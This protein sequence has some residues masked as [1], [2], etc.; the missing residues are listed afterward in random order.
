M[1][2]AG[3]LLARLFIWLRYLVALA[4]IAGAIAATLELP[5]V[6]TTGG[7]FNSLLPR[8]STALAAAKLSAG[9]F[10]LPVLGT[11]TM[12]VVRN[13]HGL[14]PSRQAQLLELAAQLSLHRLPDYRQIA[15][16]V[17]LVNTFGSRPLMRERGTTALL[18]LFFARGVGASRA[19]ALARR[20]IARRIGHR[21][22]EF[23]GLTGEL[24]AEAAQGS[25]LSS[26]LGLVE[27][28]T[29]LI[30]ALVIA[31]HF[32]APGAALLDVVTIALAFQLSEKV[33]GVLSRSAHLAFPS[34]L[35][36][37]AVVLVFGIVTDY[38]IFY[39][40]RFRGLLARGLTRREASETVL[41]DVGPIVLTAGITVAAGTIALEAATLG[42]LRSFGPGLAVAV[43]VAML[44][45][46]CF[47]PAVLGII[48]RAAFWPTLIKPAR[49]GGRLW[50][51]RP[52]GEHT[53]P[54]L[55]AMPEPRGAGRLS[56]LAERR[57]LTVRIAARHPLL[58][59]VLVAALIAA[60]ASGLR[61]TAVGNGL[62]TDLPAHS[63]VRRSFAQ[64]QR[65]FA[66]GVMAPAVVVITGADVGYRR[67]ALAHLQ[68]ELAH[69][70]GVAAVI[71][72]AQQPLDRRLGIVLAQSGTAARYILFLR[73]DPFGP[74]AIAAVARL[75]AQLP[76]LLGR[77]GLRIAH[78]AVTGDTAISADIV[79]GTI[80]SLARMVPATLVAIFIV[81][82]IF[83]R[84]LLAPAYLVITSLLAVA[85][86]LGLA[87]YVLQQLLGYGQLAFYVPFV[88]AVLMIS[89]GSDYN[90]FMVGQ[91]WHEARRRSLREAIEV[92]GSRAA[93][94]ITTAGFVLAA[95]F[96]LLALVPL[97]SFREIAFAMGAGL[98]IDALIV[99]ALLVP[100][101]ISIIG[102]ASEWPGHGL[103]AHPGFAH[104]PPAPL[105]AAPP[106]DQARPRPAA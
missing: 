28:A 67:A 59:V 45:A 99:R 23:E 6:A 34:A 5:S 22:G 76:R 103:R 72:P 44:T 27:L 15:G 38:T 98:L 79:S 61:L 56:Q 25:L 4:W 86:A 19:T 1:S 12:I 84:A 47:V 82:A 40:S 85:A 14:P 18:Y 17:P 78:G 13:P 7:S 74:Q 101:L 80:T 53:A 94:P 68:D 37:V 90:V 3:R 20:L 8:G 97:R 69:Q 2:A 24:P 42:Y 64:L 58:A 43:M 89:L 105:P 32:R 46:V 75:Q 41:R 39:L 71:G 96:G 70:P 33:L 102:V 106:D 54:P 66:P 35:K 62:V 55:A 77:A 104:I 26:R 30:S 91:I 16:A 9:R 48:G 100:A 31:V 73:E 60:G 95:S 65:G 36:P 11:Q 29:I 52:S 87:V 63:L 93:R 83:L 49:S 50:R 81:V 51:A 21:P 92:A 88:V 57:R 10:S